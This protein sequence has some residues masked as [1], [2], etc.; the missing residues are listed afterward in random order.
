MPQVEFHS[1]VQAPVAFA[2]R[3]LRK[4]TRQ[5]VAVSVTAPPQVL[6]QLDRELWTFEPLEFVAHLRV[7][8]GQ[9][10]DAALRRTPVWLCEGAPPPDAPAVLLNLGADL[11]TDAAR[12]A[13]IIEIVSAEPGQRQAARARWRECEARGWPIRHHTPAAA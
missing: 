12:Y 4:A 8:F 10:V 2:C 7:R 11:P 5:G 3:L 9:P 13:R 1:G 6:Q